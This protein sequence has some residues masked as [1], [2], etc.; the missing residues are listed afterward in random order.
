MRCA[1]FAVECC[2]PSW[3]TR[4]S[5]NQRCCTNLRLRCTWSLRVAPGW[6]RP[7]RHSRPSPRYRGRSP[8]ST[9]SKRHQLFW[10]SAPLRSHLHSLWGLGPPPAA[11]RAFRRVGQAARAPDAY[12]PAIRATHWGRRSESLLCW[13]PPA[14]RN[15]RLLFRRLIAPRSASRGSCLHPVR[16]A[17]SGLSLQ[18]APLPSARGAGRNSS[19]LRHLRLW[20][21]PSP[22][23]RARCSRQLARW[24]PPRE[25]WIEAWLAVSRSPQWSSGPDQRVESLSLVLPVLPVLPV[26]WGARRIRDP[27]TCWN[28]PC[29]TRSRS[30]E[31][32][33]PSWRVEVAWPCR[34]QVVQASPGAYPAGMPLAVR[35][36]TWGDAPD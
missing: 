8:A 36:P 15:Q 25:P 20:R 32:S 26:L 18:R 14:A 19:S 30:V 22:P 10:R 28:A 11:A 23:L 9:G 24:R 5:R 29:K 21:P 33:R 35:N 34:L 4:A 13:M 16:V 7:E 3:S 6:H 2:A 1:P 12:P 17:R 27:G 31:N